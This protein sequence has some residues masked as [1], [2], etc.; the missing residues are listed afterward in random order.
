MRTA[1]CLKHGLVLP[2]GAS[3][4]ARKHEGHCRH[5]SISKIATCAHCHSH[6]ALPEREGKNAAYARRSF[7]R[8][9][10]DDQL[11]RRVTMRLITRSTVVR[12][13]LCSWECEACA[14]SRK[15]T[16]SATDATMYVFARLA[17]PAQ[18]SYF[19][20][21][22]GIGLPHTSAPGQIWA[23]LVRVCRFG[24]DRW[25]PRPRRRAW[26]HGHID[27]LRGCRAPTGWP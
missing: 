9:C 4:Q 8:A 20:A 6:C 10:S 18:H 11:R 3:M 26:P 27:C 12:F 19:H 7:T 1:S 23:G 14:P 5:S 21:C 25:R 15:Q 2:S 24:F 22:I 17:M 13:R 16:R